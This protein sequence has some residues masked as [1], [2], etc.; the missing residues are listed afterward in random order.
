M[1]QKII[2]FLNNIEDDISALCKYIY[3]NPEESFKEQNSSTYITNMLADYNFTIEENLLDIPNCFIAKKGSA[4]PKICYLCEYDAVK[5]KGH[6]T[7]HNALTAISVSAALALGSIITEIGGSVMLIGCPGEY[8][9]GTKITL[10]K[11]GIFDDI[12]IVM[13]CHPSTSTAESGTSYAII[14]LCISFTDFSELTFLN[15]NKYTPLDALLLTIHTINS[16]SKSFPND[17]T[18]NYIISKGGETPSLTPNISEAK[19]YIR[20]K[21]SVTTE[22]IEGKLRNIALHISDLTNIK[23]NINLYEQPNEELITNKTL[24]RL[25]THNLKE[26][27]IIN[28]KPPRNINA[29]LSIG[30]VSKKVPCIHSY[31]GI[32]ENTNVKYGS[33]DFKESTIKKFALD[34]IKKAATALTFT[35]YDLIKKESLLTEVRNCFYTKEE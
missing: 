17:S 6:L 35:G 32:T 12:D 34:Q 18:V 9:G 25:F 3:N 4:H 13:E 10:T 26:S 16:L 30:T 19:F 28:I 11:Q 2:S 23:C 21:D 29:G 22:Y 31:I 27:G 1:K 7:G 15:S 20:A 14:A 24:N 5:D 33:N 8:L